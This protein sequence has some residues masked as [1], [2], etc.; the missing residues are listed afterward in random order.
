MKRKWSRIVTV[1]YY[2]FFLCNLIGN[3]LTDNLFWYVVMGLSLMAALV[4][5]VL[6]WFY[7]NLPQKLNMLDKE[8]KQ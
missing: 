6:M 8:G 4:L 2:S 3:F 5:G 7:Y 1:L